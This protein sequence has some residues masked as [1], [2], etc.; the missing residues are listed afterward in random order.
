MFSY[1]TVDCLREIVA[2]VRGR[3]VDWL[4]WRWW[5]VVDVMFAVSTLC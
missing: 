1:I 2:S 3:Q 5:V 4:S